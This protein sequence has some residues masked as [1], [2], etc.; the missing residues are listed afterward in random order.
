M[1]E[2][3]TE[4]HLTP[5]ESIILSPGTVKECKAASVGQRHVIWL[6]E[7]GGGGWAA[8]RY[9]NLKPEREMEKANLQRQKGVRHTCRKKQRWK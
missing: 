4:R 6:L 1:E 3:V 2:W 9:L 8:M 7:L 5:D